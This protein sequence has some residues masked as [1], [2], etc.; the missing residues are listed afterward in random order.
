MVTRQSKLSPSRAVITIA[1][2]KPI[3]L[4][5]AKNLA[6]SFRL[7]HPAEDVEFHL[8][9]DLQGGLDAD[10]AFVRLHLAERGSVGES[11]T[12]K[13][14]M[15][16]F[17]VC[18]ESIFIDADCLCVGHL[19]VV[20][21]RFAGRGFS[22]VGRK[23]SEGEL[24]GDIAFRCRKAGVSWTVRFCGSLYFLRKGQR[25]SEILAYARELEPK[26]E[27]L[28][29]VK[30]RGTANE[31]PLLGLAMARFGEEPI[32]EDGTIKADLMFYSG[33]PRVDTLRGVAEVSSLPGLPQHNPEWNMPALAFPKLVHFNAGWTEESTYIS[34][35]LRL[36]LIARYK[37]PAWLATA[38]VVLFVEL[39]NA[40]WSRLK[41][42]LRPVYRGVFGYRSVKKSARL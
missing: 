1:V 34:E 15:D 19:G 25:C 29:I 42:I 35:V 14:Y 16:R 12:S 10:L 28:G 24:F 26:Y 36:R 27:E 30:L 33:R 8:V 18:E 40:L 13:L 2:G 39:P 20:F 7:W 23:V 9:T 41:S 4:E 21:D 38:Y 11:F 5:Y 6:R 31:E 22:V 3:Y 17:L 37:W 32:P